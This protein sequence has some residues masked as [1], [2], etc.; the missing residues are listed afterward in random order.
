VPIRL[1]IGIHSG[2]VVVG[3]I[4]SPGRINYTVVGDAV[5]T[6]QRIEDLG[7]RVAP[8]DEVVALASAETL[9][10]LVEPTASTPAGHHDLRGRQDG[11]DVFRLA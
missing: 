1:R 5:N 7:R 8:I 4:G 3:N 11:I 9:A 6:A 2:P 10:A